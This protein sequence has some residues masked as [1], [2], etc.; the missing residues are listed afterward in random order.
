MEKVYTPDDVY[1]YAIRGDIDNLRLALNYG[2]NSIDWYRDQ[3]GFTA[4]N[5]AACLGHTAC[6]AA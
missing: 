1:D 3:Y 2:N 6:I 5:V 4:L